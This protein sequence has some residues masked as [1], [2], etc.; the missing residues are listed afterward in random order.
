MNNL[1]N[2][3]Q[4]SKGHEPTVVRSLDLAMKALEQRKAS[5]MDSIF[6]QEDKQERERLEAEYKEVGIAISDLNGMLG[7]YKFVT[8][9][10]L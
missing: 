1:T 5:I 9:Q 8:G 3:P 7:H 6:N 4:S 10:Y 2:Q